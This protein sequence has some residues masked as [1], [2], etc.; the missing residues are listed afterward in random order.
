LAQEKIPK[1]I[2]ALSDATAE[3]KTEFE[4]KSAQ[5]ASGSEDAEPAVAMPTG[6]KLKPARKARAR[7]KA[8]RRGSSR[9]EQQTGDVSTL[10]DDV[11]NELALPARRGARWQLAV[12]AIAP[13]LAAA[14]GSYA[15]SSLSQNVYAARS[16]IVFNI[17][18]LDWD[19]AER[20]LATQVVIAKSRSILTPVAA[21]FEIPVKHLEKD[22]D[23][24]IIS[25][26]GV[27]RLQYTSRDGLMALE[28]I[29]AITDRYLVTLRESEQVEGGGHRLL[30]PASL[31]EDPVSPRPSQAAAIGAV[32]G[33]AIAAAGI[34]LRTQVW[35]IR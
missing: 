27:M 20:F 24:E 29:K 25:S 11:A 33:L 7:S 14:I 1:T 18:D 2:A 10:Q 4:Q 30:T 23:V 13:V 35:P 26:S 16:E 15:V 8:G 32:A 5:E 6:A 22:L 3:A 9:A 21:T 19:P 34:I 28:V 12:L 31:I 17:R